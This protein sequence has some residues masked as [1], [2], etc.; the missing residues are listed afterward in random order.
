MNIIGTIMEIGI[1]ETCK[2]ISQHPDAFDIIST[3][4]PMVDFDYINLHIEKFTDLLISKE[5]KMVF[6]M[7]PEIALI[8]KLAA[9]DWDGVVFIPLPL[10]LDEESVER[11][12]S[13]MPK[14]ININFVPE[15]KYPTNFR[16]DNAI[17]ICTGIAPDYYRQYIPLVCCRMM[18]F[19]KSFQGDKILL[20][21]FPKETKT[22]EIGWSYTEQDFFNFIIS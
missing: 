6:M 8:E 2:V 21:C 10:D 15:G 20:S 9:S 19:Y 3:Q 13:N 1:L 18:L 12:Y 14:N 16:P 22:P 4:L 7:L 11:I 5:K 17:L